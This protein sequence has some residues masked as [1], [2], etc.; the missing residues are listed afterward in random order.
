[1]C[2][3]KCKLLCVEERLA[4]ASVVQSQLQ[5]ELSVTQ[6]DRGNIQEA[7]HKM[8]ATSDGLGQ[9]KIRLNK[10]IAQVLHFLAA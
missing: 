2:R 10:T 7:L 4:K 3:C 6:S 5:A 9:E 1:M 8:T